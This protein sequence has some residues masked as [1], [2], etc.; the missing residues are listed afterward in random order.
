MNSGLFSR[1]TGLTLMLLM[2]GLTPLAAADV[3]H[4]I[5]IN[6]MAGAGDVYDF[7]D[8]LPNTDVTAIPVG[9][10]YRPVIN[11]D[12][13]MRVDVEVGPAAIVIVDTP[14]EGTSLEYFDL[15]VSG[16]FGWNATRES[17]TNF[18]LRG[19][20]AGH[21]IDSDYSPDSSAF[22][23]LGALGVEFNKQRA[24]NGF[25]EASYDTSQIDMYDP[26][27]GVR[28]INPRGFVLAG[29]VILAF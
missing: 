22:G 26:G 11:L 17:N 23:L 18:Y 7:F 6:Y 5:V 9:L 24:V 16:T 4:A 2:A 3:D 14:G 25:I 27:V 19:G 8:D 1:A 28:E 29:G 15:G 10:S 13:G 21:L 12:H 20:V